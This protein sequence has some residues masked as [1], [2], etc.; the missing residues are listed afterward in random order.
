[1]L[2]YIPTKTSE[3]FL[4]PETI[5]NKPKNFVKYGSEQVSKKQM[6]IELL[7]LSQQRLQ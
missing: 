5:R 3:Y 4:F 6:Y 2:S 1:M 7:P